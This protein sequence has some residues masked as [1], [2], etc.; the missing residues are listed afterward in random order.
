[1][2]TNF[3]AAAVFAT[4]MGLTFTAC[5]EK[6]TGDPAG[7]SQ[8]IYLEKETYLYTT[9]GDSLIEGYTD[10][11]QYDSNNRLIGVKFGPDSLGEYE[12]YIYDAAGKLTKIEQYGDGM[13]NGYDLVEYNSS[14]QLSK[15]K[16]YADTAGRPFWSETQNRPSVTKP[17][18]DLFFRPRHQARAAQRGAGVNGDIVYVGYITFA[19]NSSGYLTGESIYDAQGTLEA[20]VLFDVD[21][22]GNATHFTYK[23]EGVKTYESFRTFTSG[24]DPRSLLLF[25]AMQGK[26]AV[27][28]ETSVSYY[29]GMEYR[30]TTIYDYVLN[31]DNYPTQ[32]LRKDNDGR[33]YGGNKYEYR[34]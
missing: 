20:E 7:S 28:K 8:S 23:E 17:E 32:A 22:N 14:G 12:K 24:L 2:K 9:F 30:D 11:Y 4:A 31:A 25:A 6:K 15:V 13:L 18:R 1:M 27:A 16:M 3:Y 19:I 29:Q 21:V 26:N 10:D 34:K 5:D 33:V